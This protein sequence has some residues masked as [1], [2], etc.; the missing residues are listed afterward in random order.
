M[1]EGRS[2]AKIT[3]VSMCCICGNADVGKKE[4][5]VKAWDTG[6][7]VVPSDGTPGPS[8]QLSSAASNHKEWLRM[9]TDTYEVEYEEVSLLPH[10]CCNL[11]RPTFLEFAPLG[12]VAAPSK[13][14]QPCM[15]PNLALWRACSWQAGSQS[16]P[17]LDVSLS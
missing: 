10:A 5:V 13:I 11:R 15:T 12:L 7:I 14:E 2:S 3:C 1:H 6:K 9:I 16:P 4:G 8:G 17:A